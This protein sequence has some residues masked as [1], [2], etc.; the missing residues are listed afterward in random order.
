MNCE[1]IRETMR[2]RFDAG[3]DP[4]DEATAHLS[5]CAECRAYH[6]RLMALD[7]ALVGLP[8]EAP[9]KALLGRIRAGVAEERKRTAVAWQAVGVAI[10]VGLAVVATAGWLYPLPVEPGLWYAEALSWI[11]TVQ[12]VEDLAQFANYAAATYESALNWRAWVPQFELPVPFALSSAML[13][14]GVA[15]VS[16]ALAGINGLH[17]A[18]FQNASHH[19]RR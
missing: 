7:A 12:P 8:L 18:N 19:T 1:Q 15:A 10:A 13:W 11:P 3:L 17:A 5:T 6:G 4:V 14:L 9:D 2:E 16:A